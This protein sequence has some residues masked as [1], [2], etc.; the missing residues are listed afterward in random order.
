MVAFNTVRPRRLFYILIFTLFTGIFIIISSKRNGSEENLNTLPIFGAI[1]PNLDEFKYMH[2][3]AIPCGSSSPQ[4]LVF[5]HSSPTNIPHRDAIRKTWGSSKNENI[6]T[7]FLVGRSKNE[8]IWK[9][10][11]KEAAEFKDLVLL[12]FVDSYKNLTLKHLLGLRWIITN[13]PDVPYILK[14]DDDTFVD[15]KRL[16]STI[17]LFLG[18]S[19]GSKN[20]LVCHVIP[21][22]TSP[23]RSGKWMVTREEYPFEEYPEYCSGLA[24]FARLSTLRKIHNVASSGRV[25][26]LRIDDVFVTGLAAT[27][28]GV[29]RQ[30]LGVRFA[31]TELPVIEW[32]KRKSLHPCPWMVAEISPYYWPKEASTLWN[33]T[34][35]SWRLWNKEKGSPSTK[36][37]SSYTL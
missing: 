1:V 36:L 29:K 12:S 25:P 4:L 22:G 13:C 34:V 9:R 27:L 18:D 6:R 10:I 26:Y 2:G 8:R 24:Y 7:I 19:S 21:D 30:D 14:A 11:E 35:L 5:I 37:K 20:S 17:H 15:T 33:K 23:K 3:T 28:A 16:V 32:V 31:N